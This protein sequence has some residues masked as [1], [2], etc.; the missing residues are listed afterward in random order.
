[1]ETHATT[2]PPL[3]MRTVSEAAA[4]A[5][6][7]KRHLEDQISEGN[8]PAVT[9]IGRRVLIRDDRLQDWIDQRTETVDR[10]PTPAQRRAAQRTVADFVDAMA[11][12]D[13]A[14]A[15][16][17]IP[18]VAGNVLALEAIGIA[19]RALRPSGRGAELW[20]QLRTEIQS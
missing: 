20:E 14:Q 7:S 2:T 1:M 4:V 10:P 8:G 15:D 9:R 17:L 19:V 11:A 16:K 12:G 18:V 3:V 13:H 6:I 5:G